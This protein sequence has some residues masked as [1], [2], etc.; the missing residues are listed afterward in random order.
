MTHILMGRMTVSALAVLLAVPS[1]AN[2]QD[3]TLT[4][5]G[6]L[7]L[8]QAFTNIKN[9]NGTGEDINVT[10]SEVRRARLFA[11]GKFGSAVSYKFEFNHTTGGDIEV[12]DGFLQFA[13]KDQPFKIKVG[14]FKTHNS[15]EEEAS[16]RFITTIERGG[17][18]DAFAL[19]RRLGLSVGTAGDKYTLNAGIYG[20]SINDDG[21]SKNGMA[22]AARATFTPIKTEDT[23]LHLGASWRYR[24]AA[25]TSNLR[26]RQRPYA[27][28]LDS[29]NT[30]GFLPSGRIINAGRIVADRDERF[31]KSDNLFAIEGLILQDN[32]WAAAEYAIVDAKGADLNPDASFGGGYIEAGI[33]FGGKRTYKSSG[34]TYNRMKVDNPIGEGGMGAV[35]LVARYDTLD[36]E[37][38]GYLGKLDTIVLGA[39]WL[40]TKNTRLRVNYFNSDAK[41]GYADSASGINARL[42]FD[43]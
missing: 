19:D 31:A 20:E 11:K 13:P 9:V 5:G 38:N 3:A 42:G 41:N 32:M 12:T 16:S 7:M 34:G 40:P 37:D 10:S 27:H 17:F 43:F 18:T 28:S 14:H 29:D 1:A 15:L 8:D 24:D 36:L 25:D 22:A 21:L 23:L 26:Y 2:A 39:D 6:R 30:Q 35:S 33:V 4:I